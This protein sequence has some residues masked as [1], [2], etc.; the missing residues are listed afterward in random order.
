MKASQL[1]VFLCLIF[2][3]AL[4]SCNGDDDTNSISEESSGEFQGTQEDIANFVSQDI[5]DT[6]IEMGLV[7]NTGNT[8]PIINGV[9]EMSPRV[10]ESTNIPN[11]Y[12]PGTEIVPITFYFENQNNDMLTFDYSDIE[13][14]VSEAAGDLSYISGTGNR[15]SAFV[16]ATANYGDNEAILIQAISGVL[17]TDG[18]T[19]T[20]QALFMF[21]NK[22]NVNSVF[23]ENGTGRI[24]VDEDGDI[25]KVESRRPQ[26]LKHIKRGAATIKLK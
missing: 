17:T 16:R 26:I 13:A 19:D 4:I 25:E 15:F 23:I 11:D 8:P 9:Y 21:D 5:L 14:G 18:F 1:H 10:V 6:W 7:I 2:S 24:F 20:Q 12:E 22:G 3:V